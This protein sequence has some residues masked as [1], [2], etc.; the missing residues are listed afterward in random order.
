MKKQE[1]IR[2]NKNA[3]DKEFYDIMCNNPIFKEDLLNIGRCNQK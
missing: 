3:L 1:I 2:L